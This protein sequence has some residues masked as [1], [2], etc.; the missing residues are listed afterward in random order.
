MTCESGGAAQYNANKAAQISMTKAYA[1]DWAKQAESS[2]DF[3][4]LPALMVELGFAEYLSQIGSGIAM[5]QDEIVRPDHYGLGAEAQA[6][7]ADAD[8]SSLMANVRDGRAELVGKPAHDL[9]AHELGAARVPV[10]KTQIG[11][12]RNVRA[13]RSVVPSVGGYVA[14]S[15]VPMSGLGAPRFTATPMPDD[16]ISARLSNP[17]A[18]A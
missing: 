14:A 16:M 10:S 8:V 18:A 11:Y 5:S 13:Y 3:G 4:R 9:H 17:R 2:G 7:L 1:L 12:T 6:F 15:T